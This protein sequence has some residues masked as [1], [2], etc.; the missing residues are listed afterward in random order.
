MYGI[1]LVTN[2]ETNLSSGSISHLGLLTCLITLAS[3]SKCNNMKILTILYVSSVFIQQPGNP[4]QSVNW[5]YPMSSSC[6]HITWKN[7]RVTVSGVQKP[8]G[9]LTVVIIALYSLSLRMY[10]I[11]RVTLVS[12]CC[13]NVSVIDYLSLYNCISLCGRGFQHSICA[14]QINFHV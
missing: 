6:L 14:L 5:R 13:V 11:I 10:G 8:K 7:I 12:V 3:I 4:G 9:E 1:I 2:F